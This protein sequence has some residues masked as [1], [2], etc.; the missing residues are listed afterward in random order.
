VRVDHDSMPTWVKLLG[1][2]RFRL[3][4][5]VWA[6]CISAVQVLAS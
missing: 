4:G 5:E 1:L 2:G 3:A 6:G